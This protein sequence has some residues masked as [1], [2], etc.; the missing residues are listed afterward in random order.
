M[1][2]GK[3]IKK[4]SHMS[5]RA[6]LL[7]LS[8]V[9]ILSVSVGGTLAYLIAQSETRTNVFEPGEVTTTTEED[10]F[11]G[12]IKE[13]V[14]VKS[15]GTSNVDAFVRAKIVITWADKAGNPMGDPVTK[16]MYNLKLGAD[17]GT[18]PQVDGF[19]YYDKILV[20]TANGGPGRTTDLI[21]SCTV[22]SGVGPVGAHL[23]VTILSQ[24]IQADPNKTAVR[25][26]WGDN[27]A[28]Y[29]TPD[30]PVEPTT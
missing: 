6:V 23:Q 17:W 26:A 29:W 28:D 5:K 4:L 16:E 21:E 15:S 11:K 18:K 8:L 25:E 7:V 22:V 1:Y 12:S 19:Y 3:R 27:A 10:P 9:M 14:Y 30:Y 13:H 2:R 20:P 24:S